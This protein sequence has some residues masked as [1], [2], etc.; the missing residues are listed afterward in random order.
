MNLATR[1]F[2]N[3]RLVH[4]VLAALALLACGI[5][6]TGGLRVTRLM[7]ERQSLTAATGHDEERALEMATSTIE[8]QRESTGGELEDL[9]AATVEANRL[10]GQRT[11]SWTEFLNLIEATVPPDVMLTS[12]RPNLDTDGFDV[13]IGIVVQSVEAIDQFIE[14]LEATGA[15]SDVLSREEEI[16]DDGSYRAVLFGRYQQRSAD[17]VARSVSTRSQELAQ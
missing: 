9:A 12:L 6:V 8:L 4:V 5:L 16:T 13:L 1:P 14:G 7:S 11:F 17:G 3:E 2:Y 15:F 10:I